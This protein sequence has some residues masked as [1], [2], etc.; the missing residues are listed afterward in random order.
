MGSEKPFRPFCVYSRAPICYAEQ[1][2]GVV[3][4]A[5]CASTPDDTLKTKDNATVQD[6]LKNT[7]TQMFPE[8]DCWWV[9]APKSN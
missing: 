6:T 7:H 3:S 8:G 9:P 2:I 5:V 1:P 4:L